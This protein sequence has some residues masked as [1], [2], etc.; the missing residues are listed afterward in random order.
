VVLVPSRDEA[1]GRVA[2]EAMKRGRAVVGTARA[3][4]AEL[5]RDGKTGRA[6]VPGDVVGLAA[7]L[8]ELLADDEERARLAR[9]GW[10]WARA[11]FTPARHVEAFLAHADRA[12][13]ARAPG[14]VR[15]AR[16]GEMA[17]T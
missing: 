3:G 14:D 6:Y 11:A 7:V 10:T 17:P 4:T 8:D 12:T 13:G 9:A 5:V 2:V 16:A 1:F 15:R